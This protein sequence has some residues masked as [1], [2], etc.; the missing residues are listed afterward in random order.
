MEL[1]LLE[2]LSD[3]VVKPGVCCS[4]PEHFE[5][6]FGSLLFPELGFLGGSKRV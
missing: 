2:L 4:F 6:L 3:T 1:L 5:L